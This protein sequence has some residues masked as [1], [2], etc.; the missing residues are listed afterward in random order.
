VMSV[1]YITA[2][3]RRYMVTDKA[4]HKNARTHDICFITIGMQGTIKLKHPHLQFIASMRLIMNR[5]WP[6]NNI[7]NN[8]NN[9]NN[10]VM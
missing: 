3:L 5:Y 6:C 4:I 8:N 9:N 1:A 2:Q 7:I 10:N